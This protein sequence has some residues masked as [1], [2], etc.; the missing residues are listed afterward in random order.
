[1]GSSLEG[2]MQLTLPTYAAPG[3]IL[4][5]VSEPKHSIYETSSTQE[6]EVGTKLVYN[7]GREFRY[8]KNGGTAL[9]KALMTTSEALYS[10]AVEELQTTYGTSAEVGDVEI[11]IDVT[12][13]GSWG[14]NEY[15]GGFL[16]I[17]KAT[18]MGDVYKIL[19]NQI[20]GSD[21]TLMRVRLETGL[22][23]ALDATSEITLVKS[24]W[25]E[26][27]VMPTTAEGAPA[28]IPL[29]AVPA[30]YYF[31]PQIKGYAPCTVDTGDTLV[32]GE[33]AGYPDT[34]N[35][36]GACGAIGA[37]T[38]A[39]WGIAVYVATAGEVGIIDLNV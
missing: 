25:Q 7:D 24:R 22:R 35:V 1:M 17:N 4:G 16:L 28:G 2:V 26:V 38:D 15:A 29:V 27:D 11:D 32:K 12:T 14:D 6:Y 3:I 9:A 36:A 8:A 34:P 23:T 5:D 30:N 18:G 21:D 33:P 20:N 19:A 37:D 13:G 10:R 31:W 39:F